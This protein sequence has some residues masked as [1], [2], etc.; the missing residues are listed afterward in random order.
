MTQPI[1]LCGL[2][3]TGARVLEYLQAARLPVVV[4]DTG[5]AP[6]DPR[7]HVL[8]AR[9]FAGLHWSEKAIPEYAAALKL[10]PQDP[11]IRAGRRSSALTARAR[12]HVA[13]R[14]ASSSRPTS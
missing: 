3:R 8:R 9:A 12:S 14:F 2:G 1:I 5:C 10:S 7:L 13:H 11:R 4:V 6:D